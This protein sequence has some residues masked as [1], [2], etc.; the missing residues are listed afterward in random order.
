MTNIKMK[1]KSAAAEDHKVIQQLDKNKGS[2]RIGFQQ[3]T[4]DVEKR[5]TLKSLRKVSKNVKRN[6]IIKRR[7]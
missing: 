1:R 6:S 3:Q 7:K 2:L 5:L 4:V